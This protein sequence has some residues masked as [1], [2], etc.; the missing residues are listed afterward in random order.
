MLQVRMS[1]CNDDGVLQSSLLEGLTYS[2]RKEINAALSVWLGRPVQ[3][4]VLDRTGEE[5]T[6]IQ[7]FQRLDAELERVMVCWGDW[8]TAASH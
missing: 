8:T 6:N 5:L 3:F 7:T 4:C 2:P 1:F